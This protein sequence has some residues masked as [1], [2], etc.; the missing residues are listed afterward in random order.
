VV[1]TVVKAGDKTPLHTHVLPTVLYVISG[2]HF[3]RRDENDAVVV[4][5]RTMNPTFVMPP[6]QWSDGIP[7]QT[8]DQTT[9]W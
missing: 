5:T 1:E 2:S 9:W 6:V 3:V 4:D 8:L 7:K